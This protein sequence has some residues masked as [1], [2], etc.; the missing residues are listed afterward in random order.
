MIGVLRILDLRCI[1]W[2]TTFNNTLGHLS[3]VL[4]YRILSWHEC[5]F[6]T[7]N[8]FTFHLKGFGMQSQ[9][10]ILKQEQSKLIY[11]AL[12][13]LCMTYVYMSSVVHA[14]LPEYFDEPILQTQLSDDNGLPSNSDLIYL[15]GFSGDFNLVQASVDGVDVETSIKTHNF[16]LSGVFNSGLKL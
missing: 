12:C 4:A 16:F 6:N 7:V 14:C 15:T 3:H 11:M 1:K 9:S 13:I 5:C 8:L 10:M 2:G